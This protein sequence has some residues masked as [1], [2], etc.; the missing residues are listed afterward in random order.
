MESGS[1]SRIE[2]ILACLAFIA[3]NRTT[4]SKKDKKLERVGEREKRLEQ[5]QTKLTKNFAEGGK[6][7]VFIR[8]IR[9][10]LNGRDPGDGTLV[11]GIP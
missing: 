11:L 8:A 4:E 5:K 1:R 10:Q 6:T 2:R 9:G 3:A 7:S